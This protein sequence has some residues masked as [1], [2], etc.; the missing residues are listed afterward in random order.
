MAAQ[1][2]KLVLFAAS[3][4]ISRGGDDILNGVCVVL[5]FL[6]SSSSSCCCF[7]SYNLLYTMLQRDVG[8][9]LRSTTNPQQHN[10][11]H[12]VHTTTT[13]ICMREW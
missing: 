9:S 7:F 1:P 13:T 5:V 10:T 8:R 3:L 12:H 4:P 2:M 6:I 11:A